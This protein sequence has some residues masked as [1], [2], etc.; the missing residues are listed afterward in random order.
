[1][2]HS[3]RTSRWTRFDQLAQ[4]VRSGLRQIRR[5]PASSGVAIA[6][7]ALAIGVNAAMFSAVD[8]VLIRPLPYSDAD[9]LVMVWDDASRTGD[10]SKFFSTPPEGHEWRPHNSV[11]TDIAASQPG[12]AS[13]SN[14]GEPEELPARKVTA[15]FWSVLGV[16][17]LLGR[18]FTEEEDVR[19]VRVVVISH[20]LWQR[21][22]NASRDILGRKITLNDGP[23]DVIGVMPREFYFM[24]TRDID[25]ADPADGE[26]PGGFLSNSRPIE[27]GSPRTG[28]TLAG[29][30]P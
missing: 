4:D 24:P 7:L 17:P 8:A 20:G 15:N 1:M 30:D 18:V 14:D 23:Y 19:G 12:D 2:K 16:R 26:R 13:L 5:S 3:N 11:F 27:H 10:D 21:R 6:T 22:F 9:R 25:L 29:G 28:R